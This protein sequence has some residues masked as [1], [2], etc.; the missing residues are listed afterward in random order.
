MKHEFK[1]TMWKRKCNL[2]NR[3]K[4]ICWDWNRCSGSGQMWKSCWRFFFLTCG[5][6]SGANSELVVLSQSVEKSKRKCQEKIPCLWRTNSWFVHHDN[7]PAHPLLL[8][9]DFWLTQTQLCFLS[10]P[11]HLTWLWQT[12]SYFQTEIHFERTTIQEIMENSQTELCTIPK[13]VY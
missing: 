6:M 3:L 13:K 4:N 2:H 8:I 10:H 9:H 7:A 1:D 11:T 12:C 5:Y